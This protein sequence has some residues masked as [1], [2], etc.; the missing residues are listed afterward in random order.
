MARAEIVDWVK[1]AYA[2]L[3]QLS[4]TPE[5]QASKARLDRVGAEFDKAS[6]AFGV[7]LLESEQDLAQPRGGERAASR[8]RRCPR[9][10]R[11]RAVRCGN[12]D[13]EAGRRRR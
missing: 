5:H 13:G 4:S 1:D 6:A 7:A 8:A 9:A 11:R 12:H 10:A 3:V 2:A